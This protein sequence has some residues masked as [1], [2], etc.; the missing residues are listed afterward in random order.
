MAL[1]RLSK[2][3][4]SK[5]LETLDPG[6]RPE[7]QRVASCANRLVVTP[8]AYRDDGERGTRGRRIKDL[9]S[10]SDGSSGKFSAMR[11]EQI[12]Q[13][14]WFLGREFSATTFKVVNSPLREIR[15]K[16][17]VAYKAT[18]P[19]FFAVVIVVIVVQR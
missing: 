18:A 10:L 6:S 5:N 15:C 13:R 12:L 9:D 17:S 11:S 14:T 2:V 8:E 16:F 7:S 3:S 1:F 19:S 4:H